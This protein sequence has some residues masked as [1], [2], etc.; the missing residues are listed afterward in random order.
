MRNIL[1]KCAFLLAACLGFATSTVAQDCHT[2]IVF[3]LDDT[4]IR[5]VRPDETAAGTLIPA[6]SQGK[7]YQFRVLDGAPEI[8]ESLSQIP[9]MCISFFSIGER[10]RNETVLS[11]MKLPSGR[12]ARE[13]AYRVL[14]LEDAT[15]VAGKPHKDLRLVDPDLKRVVIVDDQKNS[16][17]PGQERNVLWLGGKPEHHYESLKD[18]PGPGAKWKAASSEKFVIYR[19]RL[20]YARGLLDRVLTE[21]QKSGSSNLVE[22]LSALQWAQDSAGTPVFNSELWSDLSLYRKGAAEFHA[23]NSQYGFTTAYTGTSRRACLS[24][25][26]AELLKV[27]AH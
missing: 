14:S 20:A 27:P 25:A 26:I 5:W 19:N 16:P 23:V 7:Q 17:I 15:Q 10:S 18:S 3:D 4:L 12:M 11:H 6:M 1:S 9:G 2:H 24:D 21:S 13:I 22:S 8:L